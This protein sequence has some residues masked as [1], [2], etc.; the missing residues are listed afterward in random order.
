MP[1]I[2]EQA[3][4]KQVRRRK[5]WAI[6]PHP[7]GAAIPRLASAGSGIA[8]HP[9]VAACWTPPDG[10]EVCLLGSGPSALDMRPELR[11]LQELA[12]SITRGGLQWVEAEADLHAEMAIVRRIAAWGF[13]KAELGGCLQICRFG[14][15]ICVDC[16]GWLTKHGI[17]HGPHCGMDGAP[18]WTNPITHA[19]FRGQG[20]DLEYSKPAKY[21]GT[22]TR[23]N[24]Q[25]ALK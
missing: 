23:Q 17:A 20:D 12:A 8:A 24:Q 6:Q 13:S 18:S 15:P 22:V 5:F 2:W 7:A 19:L 4:A 9:W 1:T 21:T 10:G 14:D 25:A 3:V 16:C 11:F